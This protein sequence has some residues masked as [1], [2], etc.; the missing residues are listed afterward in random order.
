MLSH[1][2]FGMILVAAMLALTLSIMGTYIVF[3]RPGTFPER[4]RFPDQQQWLEAWGHAKRECRKFGLV[5]LWSPVLII[6]ALFAVCFPTD[7][8]RALAFTGMCVL[9]LSASIVVGGRVRR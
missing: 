2:Q 1:R 6:A 9:A 3:E 7:T 4:N 8:E 5:L